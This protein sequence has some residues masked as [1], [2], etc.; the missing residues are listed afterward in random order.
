MTTTIRAAGTLDLT[1]HR[2]DPDVPARITP[3]FG[4]QGRRQRAIVQVA[5][6]ATGHAGATVCGKLLELEELWVDYEPEPRDDLCRRCF[7]D[8][9]AIA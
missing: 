1:V 9:G 3:V 4:Q 7:A 8:Q 6:E 2:R 5:A